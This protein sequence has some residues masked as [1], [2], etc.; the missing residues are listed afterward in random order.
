[1]MIFGKVDQAKVD[2]IQNWKNSTGYVWIMGLEINMHGEGG[3]FNYPR[4]GCSDEVNIN[5]VNTLAATIPNRKGYYS[6]F[7]YVFLQQEN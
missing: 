4:S 7:T 3:I 5:D 6:E 2:H 1:M